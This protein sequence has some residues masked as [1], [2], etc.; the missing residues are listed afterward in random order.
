MATPTSQAASQ[1]IADALLVINVIRAGQ[2][3]SAVLQAQGIRRL[4]QMMALWEGEGRNIGYI[5]VGTVTDVLTV[6]DAAILGIVNNLAIHM[7][8]SFGASA[9]PEIVALATMGLSIIDKITA[10]EVIMDMDLQRPADYLGA[11]NIN[12]G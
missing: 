8:P 10:K 1:I 4:N 7:A 9:S 12:T 5:P 6:P 2:T 3:P 11:F